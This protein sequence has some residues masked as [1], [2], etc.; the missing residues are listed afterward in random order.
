MGHPVLRM[1]V[2]PVANLTAP[3]IRQ[4]VEDMLE[5]MAGKQGVGLAAS[6]V[7]MPKRIVV[8]FVPRGEEK[9]PLTVLINPFVEPPWP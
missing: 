1:P 4:L 8:F 6:Q 2:A 9:I 7:F 3:G 5:T